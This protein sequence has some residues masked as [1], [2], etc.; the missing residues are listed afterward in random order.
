MTEVKTPSRWAIAVLIASTLWGLD[1][2]A[3]AQAGTAQREGDGEEAPTEEDQTAQR[4]AED[5]AA[6]EYFL[7]GRAA[8]RV[9]NYEQALAHFR[10]AYRLSGRSQ[11]HYNIGIC[12][13]RLGKHHEAFE[14]FER[15][16]EGTENPSREEEVRM[17]VAV[18]RVAI[19]ESD[20][21]TQ[22]LAAAASHNATAAL[23]GRPSDRKVPRSAIIGGSTLAA[24]GTAGV[25]AMGVGLS[26]NGACLETDASGACITERTSNTW[27]AVYG[28]IGV[29]ALAGSAS[30]LVI[31]SRR[32]KRKRDT[33]WMLTPTGVLVSASF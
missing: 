12:A 16:L 6:K 2:S 17:R 10:H 1:S 25:I 9:A 29:A 7:L 14:A 24:L 13:D 18:L 3:A 19:E 21:R 28:G 27:T 20:K 30:W 32:A 11:L 4:E 5:A 8:Y 26:Q 15:Y 31:S 33:A 22:E 23:A